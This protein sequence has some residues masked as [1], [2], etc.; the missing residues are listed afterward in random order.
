M[1]KRK[2]IIYLQADPA[3]PEP[4]PPVRHSSPSKLHPWERYSPCGYKLESICNKKINFLVSYADRCQCIKN[5]ETR[6][7]V[8]SRVSRNFLILPSTSTFHLTS[9]LIPRSLYK[10]L[11]IEFNLLSLPR[12]SIKNLQVVFC[13][14]PA[15]SRRR[16]KTFLY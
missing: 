3:R 12:G 10:L 6:D 7:C 13:A 4:D 15:N 1:C 9:T 14:F 5:M 16:K 11:S 2:L 8:D